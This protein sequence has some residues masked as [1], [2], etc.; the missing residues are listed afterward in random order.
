[1]TSSRRS[2]SSRN[3]KRG[4]RRDDAVA[5]PVV[6]QSAIDADPD[7]AQRITLLN[8]NGSQVE[9][10]P[11]TPMLFQDQLVW[12]RSILCPARTRPPHRGC[13]A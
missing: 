12:L 9:F 11:M 7:I 10:G 8:A 13:T 1:M 2:R 4:G 5:A 3:S 6:A